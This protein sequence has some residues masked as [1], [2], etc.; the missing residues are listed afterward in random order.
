MITSNRDIPVVLLPASAADVPA[1]HGLTKLDPPKT[2]Q[3]GHRELLSL[4]LVGYFDPTNGTLARRRRDTHGLRRPETPRGDLR[5]DPAGARR[6]GDGSRLLRSLRPLSP[7]PRRTGRGRLR[8]HRVRLPRARTVGG[9]ARLRQALL[10]LRRRSWARHRPRTR[11]LARPAARRGRAQPR[12]GHHAGLPLPRR[13]HARCARRS[14]AVPRSQDEG[15]A[16]QADDF[17]GDGRSVA[18]A[19]HVERDR[20]R[21]DLQRPGGVRRHGGGPADRSR[22][23][24]ALVQRGA[25]HPSASA[26]GRPPC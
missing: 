15:S 11:P 19:R 2:Q 5:C 22:G 25:R 16:L 20:A 21:R 26:R 4:R 3:A 10:R 18:D 24:A 7:R 14:R 12:R 1:V 8:G 13:R 6:R 17:T 9:T 23:H